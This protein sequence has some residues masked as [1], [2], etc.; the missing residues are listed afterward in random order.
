MQQIISPYAIPGLKMSEQS[1]IKII[2]KKFPVEEEL[3]PTPIRRREY[4]MCRAFIWMV[5]RITTGKNSRQLGLIYKRDH[6]TVLHSWAMLS[7]LY[8]TC[9]ST[10]NLINDIIKTCMIEPEK[11]EKW[12]EHAGS[13]EVI[14]H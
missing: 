6:A 12:K 2:I 7:N 1:L 3:L 14:C 9:K 8:D 13:L 4:V 11:F 10:R 5:L